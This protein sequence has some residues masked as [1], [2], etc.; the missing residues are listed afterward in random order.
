MAEIAEQIFDLPVRRAAPEGVGGLADHVNSPAFAAAV[1]LCVYTHRRMQLEPARAGHGTLERIT[2]RIR[3]LFKEF[4]L[5]GLP[6][7][8]YACLTAMTRSGS[9][10]KR[11]PSVTVRESR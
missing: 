2:G 5:R 9:C 10:S 3:T 11:N 8:M 4:F 1:G 6:T 7:W